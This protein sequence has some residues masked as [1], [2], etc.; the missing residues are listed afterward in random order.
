MELS[1]GDV[2]CISILLISLI[3]GIFIQPLFM[4]QIVKSYEL[5]P[6]KIFYD[7]TVELKP[8]SVKFY[9]APFKPLFLN[10][11]EPNLVNEFIQREYIDNIYFTREQQEKIPLEYTLDEIRMLCTM[12]YGE[13]GAITGNVKV[14]FYD[15]INIKEQ[16]DMDASFMH[17]LCTMVLLNRIKDDRFPDTIYKNL[18]K[19]NQY[20]IAYTYESQSYKYLT[21]IG[22][23]WNNIANEVIECLS[24]N[25]S[26]PEN[27][28]F[29]SNFSDLGS[30]Y[31]ATIYVDTGYFRSM[32]YYAYG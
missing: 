3:I 29:Q 15:G 13:C 28:I 25:F 2:I 7:A 6:D 10:Y 17:K 23:N 11:R 12:V 18:I 14:T 24:G 1:K 26:V 9:N 27:V 19:K 20:T 30:S 21:G 16:K 4:H 32:S 31:Y 8:Q 22:S 5:F